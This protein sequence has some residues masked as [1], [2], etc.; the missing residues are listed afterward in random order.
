MSQVCREN[1]P[2]EKSLFWTGKYVQIW[3]GHYCLR[4]SSYQLYRRIDFYVNMHN[5]HTAKYYKISRIHFKSSH[6]I[7]GNQSVPEK[8]KSSTRNY[9]SLTKTVVFTPRSYLFRV[10]APLDSRCF[11]PLTET[12]G[13][14]NFQ[15]IRSAVMEIRGSVTTLENKPSKSTNSKLK[16]QATVTK[17]Q[18][19]MVLRHSF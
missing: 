13:I 17:Q 7:N 8:K 19:Y 12:E 10:N 4:T 3:N 14:Y 2:V 5:N 1:Q 15:N 16:I 9:Q 11:N 6:T 18:H